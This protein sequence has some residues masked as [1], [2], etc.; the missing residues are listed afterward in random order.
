MGKYKEKILDL[1]K[2]QFI[3][4]VG[5]RTFQQGSVARSYYLEQLNDNLYQPMSKSVLNA[6]SKGSGNEIKSGKRPAKMSSI[7]SSSALTYNLFLNNNVKFGGRYGRIGKGEYSVEF[8]KQFRTLKSSK[9]PAN[10]DAY[11][12]CADTGEAIACE[13]KM[14]EWI[15]NKPRTLKKAY[16]DSNKYFDSGDVFVNIANDL[17][18]S[19]ITRYD[20]S[21]MF[22]HAVACYNAICTSEKDKVKKLTLVNCVWTLSN[23]NLLGDDE[24]K[25]IEREKLELKE[26]NEFKKI[27]E[28][29]K[30]LFKSKGVD[31][32]I[33]FYTFNDFLNLID[34]TQA[35][36]DYLERYKL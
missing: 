19:E 26:F 32:D 21:Q 7:R 29:L 31:F 27:M 30:D 10:L 3:N 24:F 1:L 14:I 28:P 34:K 36:L 15:F 5:P 18:S 17:Q 4:V 11:L 35:E 8:E 6:Y 13:M 33:V 9:T 22:K 20:A 2:E 25:Y 16:F 12:F 23:S